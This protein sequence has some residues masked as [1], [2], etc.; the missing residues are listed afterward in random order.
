MYIIIQRVK[1][2]RRFTHFRSP[3]INTYLLPVERLDRHAH[4]AGYAARKRDV[5]WRGGVIVLPISP[6]TQL[7]R[8]MDLIYFDYSRADRTE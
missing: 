8:D 1:I 3:L 6:E 4:K 5:H 7:T 2:I